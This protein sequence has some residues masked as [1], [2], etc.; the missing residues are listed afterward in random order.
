MHVRGVRLSGVRRDEVHVQGFRMS[1]KE[2]GQRREPGRSLPGYPR[3]VMRVTARAYERGG[4]EA[5]AEDERGG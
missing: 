3:R 1:S 5:R 2:D 4:L